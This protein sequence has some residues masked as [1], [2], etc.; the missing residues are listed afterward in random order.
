MQK[1]LAEHVFTWPSDS[2]Q[3]IG[4]RWQ[5]LTML[6]QRASGGDQVLPDQLFDLSKKVADGIYVTDFRKPNSQPQNTN[7]EL[8][9]PLPEIENNHSINNNN[10]QKNTRKYLRDSSFR[11]ILLSMPVVIWPSKEAFSKGKQGKFCFSESLRIVV[12]TNNCEKREQ[13]EKESNHS[14]G[15]RKEY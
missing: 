8:N 14:K 12:H 4:P 2:P 9:P 3:L 13:N 7:Q 6:E 5:M 11:S 10:N 15:K 1:A